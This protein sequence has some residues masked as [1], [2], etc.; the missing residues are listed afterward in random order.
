MEKKITSDPVVVS[1]KR[2]TGELW[3][4]V[5]LQDVIVSSLLLLLHLVENRNKLSVSKA[6]LVRLENA[7]VGNQDR[8]SI[9]DGRPGRHA[10]IV[11]FGSTVEHLTPLNSSCNLEP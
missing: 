1:S 5:Q 4:T 10:T 6:S 3:T 11:H 7:T 9:G 2:E 8:C